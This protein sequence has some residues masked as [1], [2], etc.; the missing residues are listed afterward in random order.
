M[1]TYNIRKGSQLLTVKGDLVQLAIPEI[2]DYNFFIVNNGV[3][4]KIYHVE[5]GYLVSEGTT[6]QEAITDAT[7]RF[8]DVIAKGRLD[9]VIKT[10]IDSQLKIN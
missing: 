9:A 1:D 10:M 7:W 2:R 3:D 5:T 8:K 4:K 6:I